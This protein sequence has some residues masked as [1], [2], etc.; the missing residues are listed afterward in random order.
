MLLPNCAVLPLAFGYWQS[1]EKYTSQAE[2]L[3]VARRYRDLG[4]PLDVVVQDWKTWEGELWGEKHLDE[5]RFPDVE[6]MKKEMERMH[7]HT[8]ISV[9]PN[10]NSGG[11]DHR[12]FAEAGQLLHDY[13]TYNA[14]DPAARA[15]YYRQAEGLHRGF[16]GWWCDNTE[17]FTAPDWC[18]ETKLPEERRFAL[19]GSEHEKYLGPERAN[20]FALYHARGIWENQPDKPVVNLTRSGWAGIQ[21]YGAI[22][23]AGDTSATWAELK[24]EIAK[25]LSVGLSGIPYWTVDAGAF[26]VGAQV[27]GQPRSRAGMVL[28]RRLRRRRGGPGLPGTLHPV[29]PIRLLPAHLPQPRHRH[30]PGGVEFRGTLPE[31]HRGRHPPAIPADALHPGHGPAGAG[32]T[33]HDDAKPLL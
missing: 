3:E 7:V 10:M 16:D 18:G 6:A 20:L 8:L 1:K 19:V 23:W 4:V 11:R 24:R 26:F 33:L 17:P 28:G 9:W 5:K 21:Q 12:E 32:G 22:L 30:A 15:R 29:A 31:R 14:F 27:V 25:G 2:L 13:S